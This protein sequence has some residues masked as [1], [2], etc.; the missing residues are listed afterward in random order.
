[1]EMSSNEGSL[2]S[3]ISTKLQ[4]DNS[5]DVEG[6]IQ[7]EGVTLT[8]KHVYILFSYTKSMQ[9]LNIYIYRVPY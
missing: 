9:F 2:Y 3:E 7:N 5:Q 4:G 1:M 8:S 6:N